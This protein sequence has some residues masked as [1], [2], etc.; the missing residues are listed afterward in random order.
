MARQAANADAMKTIRLALSLIA[1]VLFSGCGSTGSASSA[2]T[3][4]GSASDSVAKPA[5][6]APA[7]ALRAP[8]PSSSPTAFA[9]LRL[10]A[11][12][13]SIPYGGQDC[14]CPGFPILFGAWIQT[15]LGVEVDVQNLSQ[16][17]NNTASRMAVELP[18][19]PAVL[20][21]LRSADIITLTIGHNDTP[22]NSIDD[23]C[24][25]DHGFFDGNAK[26]SWKALVGPCL[27]TEVDRYRRNLTSILDQIVA[28]RAGRPTAIRF[29]TQYS[30]ISDVP[31]G[32]PPCCPP[33]AITVFA[34]VKDAF[35]KAACEIVETHGAICIDVYHAFNGPKGTDPPG[36]LLAP[37]GTHPS[38]AGHEKIAELLEA[39][40]L[41][42]IR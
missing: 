1:L 14:Q 27:K 30:D 32:D 21:A 36:P 38:A 39:A 10:V 41:A 3:G 31:G 29:T 9:G 33:E 4:A 12:G 22:W 15:T 24:D 42:P 19:K 2:A 8:G 23:A 20:E 13:D 5:S 25:A 6:S 11:V 35:N 37:D 28:L 18:N 26:A 7:S 17:D 16:H 40:G 34:T